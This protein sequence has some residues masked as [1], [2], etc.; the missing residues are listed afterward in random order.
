MR[1]PCSSPAWLQPAGIS[2]QELLLMRG[3]PLAAV[4]GQGMPL[5][6]LARGPN[7]ALLCGCHR[8]VTDREMVLHQLSSR[9]E[10]QR[11]HTETSGP[12]LKEAHLFT[13]MAPRGLRDRLR[14]SQTCRGRP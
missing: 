10:A 14:T 5:H 2:Q 3:T 9:G 11:W 1:F 12:S 8:P 4:T 7:W 6:P 13:V